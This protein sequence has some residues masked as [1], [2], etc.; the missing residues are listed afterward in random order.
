VRGPLYLFNSLLE[1]KLVTS[2]RRRLS[3]M[4][5]K[6][7]L[8]WRLILDEMPRTGPVNMAFDHALAEAVSPGCGVV[9]IYGWAPPTVSFGRNEPALGFYDKDAAAAEGLAFVRRPT[10][11]RAV[12][13]ADEVTY[14]VAV[15]VGAFGG[16]RDTYLQINRGLV[17]GLAGVGL[18]VEVAEGMASLP[19]DAGPCF[20]APVSGEVMSGGRK[21]VGSAQVRMGRNLLQHGSVILRGDQSVL[22]RLRGETQYGP[23]PATVAESLGQASWAG[24]S[25]ALA[26]GLRVALGGRWRQGGYEPAEEDAAG[27][28]ATERYA[29]EAWTWRR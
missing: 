22:D 13:H 7:E 8:H 20:Q 27:R 14:A 2:R 1:P 24:I 11:G 18:Q 28:L 6:V 3:G 21:L 19:P 16:L 12:L 26:T 29:T 5:G 15:P 25:E 10:G 23:Q 9:R 4:P 17:E